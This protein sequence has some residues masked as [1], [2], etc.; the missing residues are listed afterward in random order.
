VASLPAC[1]VGAYNFIIIVRNIEEFKCLIKLTSSPSLSSMSPK[2]HGQRRLSPV[3]GTRSSSTTLLE[4]RGQGSKR[5]GSRA[6]PAVRI[7][8]KLDTD[9]PVG[10]PAYPSSISHPHMPMIQ[11]TTRHS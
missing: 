10:L 2:Q 5:L 4:R 11:A 8:T 1:L 6:P 7:E 3:G 9:L